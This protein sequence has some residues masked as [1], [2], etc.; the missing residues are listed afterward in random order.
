MRIRT[1]DYREAVDHLPEGATL[2][3]QDVPWEDYEQIL[4]DLADR[5]RVRV[6]YDQGR[7]EIM[8]PL[9]K[10]EK[11]QKFI[12]R[13]IDALAAELRID[14]EFSGSTTWKRKKNARGAEPDTSFHVANAA[15]V[16]GKDELD[17]DVDP[18]PDLV[19]EIEVTNESLSKLPIYAALSVPEIWRYAVKRKCLLIYELRGGSYVE[20]QASRAFPMLTPQILV[21][22]I[23]QS[24]TG[25]QTKAIAAFRQW[26]RTR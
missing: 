26:L 8:S 17:L 6:S 21:N 25:G 3:L 24:K 15:R 4:E 14:V 5:P 20:V 18:P 2:V 13:L 12:D 11:Y 9:R 7:L 10:H 16:I 1:T 23:E 22:F 19:V